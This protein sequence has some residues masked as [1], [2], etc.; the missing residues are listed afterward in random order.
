MIR[1]LCKYGLSPVARASPCVP[2][3]LGECTAC[4]PP[5]LGAGLDLVCAEWSLGGRLQAEGAPGVRH[6]LVHVLA[7]S[8][9]PPRS[10]QQHIH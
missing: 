7:A 2:F 9:T 1:V 5:G 8:H 4:D 3:A 6:V 10:G